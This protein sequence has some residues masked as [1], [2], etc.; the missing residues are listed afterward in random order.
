MQGQILGGDNISTLTFTFSRIMRVSTGAD[1]T[2][3]PSIEQSVMASGRGRGRGRD[4]GRD[5]VGGDGS[6][7]GGCG[8]SGTKLT[9]SDKRSRLCKHYGRTNHI[10][11]KCW[12]KFDSPEWAQLVDINTPLWL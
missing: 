10:S 12:E 9:I 5:F 6:F 11:D 3:A 1:V 2:T 8:S 4:R 7:G